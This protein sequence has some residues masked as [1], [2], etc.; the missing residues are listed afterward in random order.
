MILSA[1]K[2]KQFLTTLDISDFKVDDTDVETIC[3]VLETNST[4]ASLFLERNLIAN[5]GMKHFAYTLPKMSTL[6]QLE[7]W[8]N[9]FGENGS[10]GFAMGLERNYSLEK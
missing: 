8:G 5:V 4:L 7:L 2:K 10:R 3:K 1:L 6:N 9:I